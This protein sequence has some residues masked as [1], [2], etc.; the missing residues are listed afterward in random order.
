MVKIGQ[1][2][3]KFELS[4]TKK[5]ILEKKNHVAV[6]TSMRYTNAKGNWDQ[7]EKDHLLSSSLKK[8]LLSVIQ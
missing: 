1:F 2:V 7:A 8:K 3:V 4:P 6:I 5:T